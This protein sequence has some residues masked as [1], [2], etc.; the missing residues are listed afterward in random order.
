MIAQRGRRRNLKIEDMGETIEMVVAS[1]VTVVTTTGVEIGTEMG[2]VNDAALTT[3]SGET[4][5]EMTA[6]ATV[7]TTWTDTTAGTG[8]TAGE[9]GTIW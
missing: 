1:I 9:V 2:M 3:L 4:T 8:S 7:V 5:V 6:R